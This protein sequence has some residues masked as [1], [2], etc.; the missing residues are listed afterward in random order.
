MSEEKPKSFIHRAPYFDFEIEPWDE[1]MPYRLTLTF[2][3]SRW[4]FALNLD[5]G[6]SNFRLEPTEEQESALRELLRSI[7]YE[8]EREI[9]L[10]LPKE[11]QW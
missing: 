10:S 1:Y 9:R 8:L 6:F 5:R 4:H 2:K 7:V 11:W 3:K